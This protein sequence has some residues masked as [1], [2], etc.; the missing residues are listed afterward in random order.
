MGWAEKRSSGHW[1]ANYRLPD[2]RRRS[3]G[4]FVHKKAAV[5][6]A[7]L[8][9]AEAHAPGWRDP[10]TA[11]IRFSTWRVQWARSRTVKPGTRD[12]DD[13]LIGKY[14]APRWDGLSLAKITR[15]DIR[16]WAAELRAGTATGASKPLSASTVRNAVRVLS[17]ALSAAVDAEIL[18]VNPALRLH[19]P[20]PAP[21]REVHLTPDE[22]SRI[23]HH[24]QP[25]EQDLADYL[26]GTGNRFG[27]GAGLHTHRPNLDTGWVRVVETLDTKRRV[28]QPTP[29]NKKPRSVPL[30]ASL[31]LTLQRRLDT[32]GVACGLTHEDGTTCRN[33]LVFTTSSGTA[34]DIS[35]F[36]RRW[37]TAAELEGMGHVRVHDL[38]HTYASWQIQAGVPLAVVGQ[39]LG[40][41]S[42]ATTQRYAHLAP[43]DHSKIIAAADWTSAGGQTGGSTRD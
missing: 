39:L 40:H 32:A 9:E 24:L 43:P 1:Q 25:E 31:R 30:T 19:L 5:N 33:G 14:V 41:V 21:A 2:G 20:P 34:W 3:A 35:N 18:A 36:R 42:P 6:A 11:A 10:A 37:H 16:V 38:R 13:W 23:R 15:H 4:T 26:V 27:E 28:I 8:A 29:K 22:Y 12:R 7:Q 17:G